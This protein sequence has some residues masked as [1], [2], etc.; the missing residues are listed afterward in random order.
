MAMTAVPGRI[1]ATLRARDDLPAPDPPATPTTS[2]WSLPF[3]ARS[4]CAM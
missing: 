4:S 1:E 3:L 2:V